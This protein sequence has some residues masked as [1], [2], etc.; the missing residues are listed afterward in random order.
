VISHTATF[1]PQ[2]Q[3]LDSSQEI[4]LRDYRQ[5]K[6]KLLE[7]D[8]I[9]TKNWHNL[10]RLEGSIKLVND[11]NKKRERTIAHIRSYHL[12]EQSRLLREML[13]NCYRQYGGDVNDLTYP[14]PIKGEI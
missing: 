6:I 4:V 3:P 8:V 7:L 11:V 2:D 12:A 1:G 9:S 14:M 5:L 10:D 13:I